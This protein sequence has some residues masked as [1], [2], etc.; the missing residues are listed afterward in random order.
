MLRNRHVLTLFTSKC[1]SRNS[2]HF[3]HISTLKSRPNMVCFDTFDCQMCFA[4]QWRALFNIATSKSA[5]DLKCFDTLYFQ[6][7]SHHKGMHFFDT[8]T[9]KNAPKPR[10][11]DTFSFKMCFVPQRCAI[12]HLSSGQLATSAPAALA[13]TF[14]HSGDTRQWKNTVFRDFPTF[15]HTCGVSLPHLLHV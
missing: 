12:F 3:F 14:R 13:S 2:L 7:C 15:S 5:P 9:C 4:P 8:S 11:F 6:M 10:C 1:A